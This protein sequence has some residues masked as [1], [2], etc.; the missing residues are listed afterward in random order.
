MAEE[1]AVITGLV[2]FLL[3]RIHEDEADARLA[4]KG[5][6]TG[7][8]THDGGVYA[9]HETNDVADWFYNDT[10]YHV[11]RWDPARVLAECDAKRRIIEHCGEWVWPDC[12]VLHLLALPYA[13][14]PD[15]RAEWKP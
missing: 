2:E 11:A 1:E 6:P 14:H 15:Y 9:G 5:F 12:R 10:A 13:D 8:W 7:E 3:A 4:V